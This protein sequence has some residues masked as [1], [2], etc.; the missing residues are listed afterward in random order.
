MADVKY[1]SRVC[2]TGEARWRGTIRRGA[3]ARRRSA[4]SGGAMA[5][6][7]GV[8]ARRRSAGSGES[9]P[10]E[11]DSVGNRPG[12]T[13]CDGTPVA[14]RARVVRAGP[15]TRAEAELAATRAAG[16]G[17]NLRVAW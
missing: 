13:V 15:P 6:R 2:G 12:R 17:R 7:R 10:R 8:G 11:V 16:A 1:R 3:G 5:I 4:G 9:A 14:G